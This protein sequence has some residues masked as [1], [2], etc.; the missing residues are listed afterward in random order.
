MVWVFN[1]PPGF[2]QRLWPCL[3]EPPKHL[4]AHVVTVSMTVFGW[5]LCEKLQAKKPKKRR[6]SLLAER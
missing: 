3:I 2:R 6:V 5:F 4:W 1:F